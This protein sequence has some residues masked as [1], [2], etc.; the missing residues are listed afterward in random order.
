MQVVEYQ[1]V[2]GQ[3]TAREPEALGGA[4]LGLALAYG[5][6]WLSRGYMGDSG[7][8]KLGSRG[9]RPVTWDETAMHRFPRA[10]IL[11]EPS[12]GKSWLLR[13][14]ACRLAHVACVLFAA[15]RHGLRDLR[16]PV[17]LDSWDLRDRL[18]KRERA[19]ILE[20]QSESVS[21]ALIEIAREVAASRLSRSVSR[22]FDKFMGEQLDTGQCT[23]IVDGWDEVASSGPSQS[24]ASR[25]GSR[26]W[27]Q[28]RLEAFAR[29]FEQVR[30]L[31]AC[32]FLGYV[33]PVTTRSSM[34]LTC[35]I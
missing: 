7:G 25:A 21:A 29:R 22:R 2:G 33:G 28:R 27:L 23:I 11:G 15:P 32:R 4:A 3:C 31:L 19:G 35:L 17:L 5:H 8:N 14:E 6:G 26:E 13:Q 10:V 9:Q 34:Y 20:E 18:L 24:P 16:I 30:V 1:S 12:S